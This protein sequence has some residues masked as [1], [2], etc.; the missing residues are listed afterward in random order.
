MSNPDGER[1]MAALYD[2]EYTARKNEASIAKATDLLL[3]LMRAE[4]SHTETS[5]ALS[6]SVRFLLER[7]IAEP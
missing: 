3:Q 2:T 4:G 1:T 6:S 5:R 7:Y